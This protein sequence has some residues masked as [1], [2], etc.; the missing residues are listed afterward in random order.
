M[1]RDKADEL[2]AS[3][4]ASSSDRNTVTLMSLVWGLGA[5]YL[6]TDPAVRE[7]MPSLDY[8]REQALRAAD[9]AFFQAI[10]D[11]DLTSVQ[12]AIL[13]GSFYL[14]NGS[15]YL[16]FGI[17]GAGTKCAQAIGL[18]RQRALGRQTTDT[19]NACRIWWA[20]EVFDK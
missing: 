4:Y 7:T 12:I 19:Q 3:D 13:L 9:A 16:G 11:P 1:F 20:L 8:L 5:H 10:R 2:L 6:W 15:P 17:L 18:H 14:F